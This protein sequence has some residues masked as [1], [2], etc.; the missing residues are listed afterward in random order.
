MSRCMRPRG[1][2]A[3]ELSEAGETLSGVI[4]VNSP[5]DAMVLTVPTA[6]PSTKVAM[7]VPPFD[8]RSSPRCRR[9]VYPRITTAASAVD[10]R[11]VRHGVR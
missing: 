7:A 5:P 11:V 4:R 8:P 3:M 9:E 1:M 2:A 6:R 10:A